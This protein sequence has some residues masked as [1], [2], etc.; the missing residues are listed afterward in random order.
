MKFTAQMPPLV[1]ALATLAALPIFAILLAASAVVLVVAIPF[2]PVLAYF[3]Q[4][5]RHREGG[6]DEDS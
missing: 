2:A 3:E 6:R 1:F 5:R 4:R